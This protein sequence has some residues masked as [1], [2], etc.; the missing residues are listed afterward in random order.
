MPKKLTTNKSI[1]QKDNDLIS[2]YNSKDK[3]TI[4]INT[5]HLEIV[6]DHVLFRHMPYIE[7]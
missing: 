3:N 5:R 7:E 4:V 1:V 6:T 2:L